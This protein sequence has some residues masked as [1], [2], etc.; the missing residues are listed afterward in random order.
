MGQ[1]LEMGQALDMLK[2]S[3]LRSS[4]QECK[5]SGDGKAYNRKAD[6]SYQET[7]EVVEVLFGNHDMLRAGEDR[8]AWLDPAHDQPIE[9][10]QVNE[11]EDEKHAEGIGEEFPE[12]VTSQSRGSP[13]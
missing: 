9:D 13:K 7:L 11:V 5:K 2:Y 8:P 4:I 6:G 1:A 10:E 12:R 3:W